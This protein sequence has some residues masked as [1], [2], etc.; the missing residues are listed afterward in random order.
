M[1]LLNLM[2]QV[3][4]KCVTIPK[5]IT[6]HQLFSQTSFEL[7]PRSAWSARGPSRRKEGRGAS[8]YQQQI[9]RK[10]RDAHWRYIQSSC[11]T[12]WVNQTLEMSCWITRSL[13]PDY[14]P[15]GEI[16]SLAC[17][18]K[19]HLEHITKLHLCSLLYQVRTLSELNNTAACV[20]CSLGCAMKQT[21]MTNGNSSRKVHIKPMSGI[22]SVGKDLIQRSSLTCEIWLITCK[23]H[24]LWRSETALPNRS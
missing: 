3:T 23:T 24:K 5:S 22:F 20:S 14:V 4:K 7:I 19:V 13:S 12:R 16:L 21:K 15:A 6:F 9:Q 1:N 17:L 2:S 18:R 11:Q 8:I 10:P